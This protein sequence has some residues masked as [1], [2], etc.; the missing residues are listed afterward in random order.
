MRVINGEIKRLAL[1]ISRWGTDIAAWIGNRAGIDQA[2]LRHGGE[3]DFHGYGRIGNEPLS[4]QESVVLS[5][6]GNQHVFR[7]D[8]TRIHRIT[9]TISGGQSDIIRAIVGEVITSRLIAVVAIR[10]IAEEYR[11]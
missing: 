10:T 4:A 6:D 1:P 8:R 11:Q 5:R 3:F 2:P 7:N 9:F